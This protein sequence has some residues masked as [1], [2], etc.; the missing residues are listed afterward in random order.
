MAK[1]LNFIL[2]QKGRSRGLFR[3]RFILFTSLTYVFSSPCLADQTTCGNTEQARELSLLIANDKGQQRL[4]LKCNPTLVM[5]AET[6]AKDMAER[7]LVSHFLGGSPNTRI[8]DAGLTLPDYYGDA[9]SNQ[10]EALAGGYTTAEDVWYALKGSTSHRQHL[11]AELPFY[12]EQDQI[13]IAFYK[14]YSTPHVEYW[15]IYLTKLADSSLPDSETQPQ[16]STTLL[17]KGQKKF[18][19]VPDKGLGIVTKSGEVTLKTKKP[20]E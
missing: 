13:G 8:R 14:D 16:T 1:L 11:L 15:A 3:Q 4:V 6:K 12:Q 18:E 20:D 17:L 9:M 19:H 10:V 7:G 5:L 2:K